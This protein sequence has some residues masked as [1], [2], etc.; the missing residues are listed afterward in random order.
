LVTYRKNPRGTGF[1]GM[2]GSWKEAEKLR[3]VRCRKS[4]W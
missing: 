3:T 4:H 2:K 1:E